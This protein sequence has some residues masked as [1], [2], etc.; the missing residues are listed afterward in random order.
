MRSYIRK[1]DSTLGLTAPDFLQILHQP[2]H[3]N[4]ETVSRFITMEFHR[5]AAE[6]AFSSY[7]IAVII[8][9]EMAPGPS[10][11]PPLILS[12]D[13]DAWIEHRH[14]N[15]TSLARVARVC[16]ATSRVALNIL[17]K[18]IDSIFHLIHL[19]PLCYTH[20]LKWGKRGDLQDQMVS[21]CTRLCG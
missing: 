14:Q 12:Y 4:N 19:V 10:L 17:W 1:C 18:Y 7:D 6:R 8:L 9:E 3:A 11:Q 15:R 5:T 20:D 13:R 2:L 16:R 21:S